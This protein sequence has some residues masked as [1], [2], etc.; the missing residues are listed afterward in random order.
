MTTELRPSLPIP[1][2]L[3]GAEPG[4]FAHDTLARRLPGIARRAI[5]ENTFPPAVTTALEALAAEMPHGPIRPLRD[6]AAPDA[7]DWARYV[8]PYVGMSWL[9][10]PWFFAETYFFRRVLEATGYFGGAGCGV[11]PYALQ[12][13]A[14]LELIPQGMAVSVPTRAL[15]SERLIQSLLAALWGNQADLSLW[16]AEQGGRP[17]CGAAPAAERL[18]ADDIPA[19]A[20]HILGL[21][22]RGARVDLVLDN[23]GLE[24]LADLELV[25]VLL[26]LDITVALHAK[27]HPTYVSDVTE[28][29]LSATIV[30]LGAREEPGMRALGERLRTALASGRALVRADWF[31]TSPLAGW[32]L[33]DVLRS[34]LARSG[35]IISKGDANYRRWLG[36]R[37]WPYDAPLERILSYAPA[38]LALLRTCKSEVAAGIARPR[39]ASAAAQDPSWLT[40]GRW[41]V[42]QFVQ[43]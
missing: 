26:S 35:L 14:G 4:S 25:D 6:L 10:A 20:E 8:A 1:M 37:H 34:G 40:N 9:E 7:A 39:C 23:A 24:L 27:P 33:P 38:P 5:A 36:D 12:K 13:R 21:A 16:P 2:P 18:L 42:V 31:W 11:D 43:P 28:A 22:G 41:G 15:R 32:E 3:R 17:L 30:W 19:L 29:D